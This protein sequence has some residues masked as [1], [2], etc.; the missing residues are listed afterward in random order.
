MVWIA[1]NGGVVSSENC[2]IAQVCKFVVA[3]AANLDF[4]LVNHKPDSPDLAA[5]ATTDLCAGAFSWWSSTPIITF[6]GCFY[7]IF[8][9][10]LQ[11]SC[12]SEKSMDF[13]LLTD[14]V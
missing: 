14:Y 11:Q 8:P 12:L 6:P 3:M 4:E 10:L 5:I 7:L 1:H 9:Q 2:S 13:V